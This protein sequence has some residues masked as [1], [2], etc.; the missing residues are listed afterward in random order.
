ME[1]I[2][3]FSVALFWLSYRFMC[4]E[5]QTNLR[6]SISL[7][8]FFT[9]PNPRRPS[10]Q[11]SIQNI[12][13]SDKAID[14]Y[15]CFVRYTTMGAKTRYSRD[16]WQ[17]NQLR[18]NMNTPRYGTNACHLC[19][20]GRIPDDLTLKVSK[21]KTCGDVHL[22]LSLLRPDQATCA[23]G[24]DTYR[25]LCCPKTF[26]LPQIPRPN[27]PFLSVAA[28]LIL[29][30]LYTR[31]IRRRVQAA[32][33]NDDEDERDERGNVAPKSTKYQRMK[34]DQSHGS[35]SR[36]K[37][38]H[39]NRTR[40]KSRDRGMQR[41]QSKDSS[42]D[43]AT[44]TKAP[45]M[46]IKTFKA[47]KATNNTSNIL[48]KQQRQIQEQYYKTKQVHVSQSE[49]AYYHLDDDTM[50]NDSTL[51]GHDTVAGESMDAVITQVV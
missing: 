2:G 31:R 1:N 5:R 11:E 47:K 22:E 25:E 13:L 16:T 3:F 15:W 20:R 36:K 27:K 14:F 24:Q 30:W 8:L 9:F 35:S 34:D 43:S 17:K 48:Q 40:S 39:A 44:K 42:K 23:A 28:G 29:F 18:D 19:D 7:N 21:Y 32:P 49:D 38:K 45:P 6:P 26:Q 37:G 46:V 4:I 10:L 12:P 41:N 33:E 50:Y 51:A